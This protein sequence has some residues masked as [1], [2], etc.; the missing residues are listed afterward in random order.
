[1]VNQV[2]ESEKRA[3]Q[4]RPFE[5]HVQSFNEQEQDPRIQLTTPFGEQDKLIVQVDKEMEDRDD[6]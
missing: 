4:L 3:S 2:D 5:D 6:E 1:M